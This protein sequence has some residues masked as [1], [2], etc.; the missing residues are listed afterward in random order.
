MESKCQIQTA[1]LVYFYKICGH[2][3]FLMFQDYFVLYLEVKMWVVL[4]LIHHN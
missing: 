1:G 2:A 4:K 3:N